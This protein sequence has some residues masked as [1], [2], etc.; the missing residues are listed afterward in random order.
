MPLASSL[1]ISKQMMGIPSAVGALRVPDDLLTT[2]EVA[3]TF[4]NPEEVTSL[5]LHCITCT[6]INELTP[7]Y[8]HALV[9]LKSTMS[10]ADYDGISCRRSHKTQC[11]NKSSYQT[12]IRN[13]GC[14]S[15]CQY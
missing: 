2:T 10:I 11:N 13:V 14:S 8:R 15:K 9:V 5:V 3:I 12:Q 7:R 1:L 4:I 6:Q